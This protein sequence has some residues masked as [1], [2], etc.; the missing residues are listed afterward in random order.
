MPALLL[1]SHFLVLIRPRSLDQSH[2]FKQQ[3]TILNHPLHLTLFRR[4]VLAARPRDLLERPGALSFNLV[5]P[6][7]IGRI[8]GTPD[9]SELGGTQIADN[10]RT[11]DNLRECSD[12]ALSLAQHPTDLL[13]AANR[14][15]RH[16]DALH[17]QHL[18]GVHDL[19]FGRLGVIL[20]D[21]K[22]PLMQNFRNY[23]NRHPQARHFRGESVSKQV[24]RQVNTAALAIEDGGMKQEAQRRIQ[25]PLI[26]ADAI[27][28]QEVTIGRIA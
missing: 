23:L 10:T 6:F 28:L 4:Q 15:G 13:W 12:L 21:L 24:R 2:L 22:M 1:D 27:P 11:A 16:V 5:T 25:S 17:K 26:E 20:G 18:G 19:L 7:R 9:T 14:L 3:L 8:A